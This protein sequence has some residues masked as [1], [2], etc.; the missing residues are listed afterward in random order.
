[1]KQI[2]ENKKWISIIIISLVVY[3][4][5]SYGVVRN[6]A[7]V[8][9]VIVVGIGFLYC[10]ILTANDYKATKNSII[11]PAIL[12][13]VV[14]VFFEFIYG[15]FK[16]FINTDEYSMQYTLLTIVPALLC[17]EILWHNK[18]DILDIL[19]SVGSFVIIVVFITN[20]LYDSLWDEV[21]AGVLVRVGELPGASV[22]DTGNLYL[23]MLIPILYAIIVERKRLI[24][25]IPTVVG[26]SGILLS[27]SKSS[28]I[29]IVFVFAIL[30]IGSSNDQITL[31]KNICI[32]L[33]VIC[34]LGIL[35][36]FVPL[37]NDIVIGRIVELLEEANATEYNFKTSTGQRKAIWDAFKAHFFEKP[38]LGHGFYAFKEMP[39]SACTLVKISEGVY[40][41][42]NSQTHMNYTEILFSFG[43]VGFILY[44]WLPV[45]LLV[46]SFLSK[47]RVG[48][49]IG[50]S[51][52][53]SFIFIDMGLDM[54]YKYMTPYYVYL[55]VYILVG[56]KDAQEE[57]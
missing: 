38:I 48:K 12:W 49:M 18:D 15:H 13:L 35:C 45:L 51:M 34:F 11:N 24:L 52:L 21:R 47:N 53:V 10:C 4:R 19:T 54:F 43:I 55:L 22:I 17:Y 14:F 8:M 37:L 27:G 1:M 28:L 2:L 25:L 41:L 23:L 9:N 5:C 46:K 40:E 33:A 29:P 26:I 16:L 3:I 56:A 7:V 30:F 20:I 32:F 31:K 36:Y 44:Y 39:Y 57:R 6:Y 50:L 42:E